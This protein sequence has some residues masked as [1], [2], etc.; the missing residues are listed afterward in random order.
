MSI[1]FREAPFKTSGGT[2]ARSLNAWFSDVINVAEFGSLHIDGSGFGTGTGDDAAC[3]Q[4][5]FDLAFGTV[6]APHGLTNKHLNRPVFIP[7]GR[8]QIET[9][10][11]LTQIVGGHISGAG[12]HA[13]LLEYSGSYPGG[14]V[15]LTPLLDINGATGLTVERMS[16]NMPGPGGTT[17]GTNSCAINLDWADDDT[18]SGSDGLHHNNFTDVIAGGGEW[19]VLI[20]KSGNEGHNNLFVNFTAATGQI[21]FEV[22]GPNAV[23]NTVLG[24]VGSCRVAYVRCPVGGGSIHVHGAGISGGEDHHTDADFVMESGKEMTLSGMRTE[25]HHCG[26][27]LEDGIVT[28]QGVA[29][30]DTSTVFARVNGGKLIMEGNVVGPL[31]E[32][33]GTGGEL[34]LSANWFGSPPNATPLSGYSGTVRWN[35]DLI[36]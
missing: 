19:A 34:Y 27:R 30:T 11:K 23:G 20:A 1:P 18:A 9:P 28:M 12:K 33:I 32:V 10:L 26:L 13:T 3:F 8:Y 2:T 6:A 4:A 36:A 21:G 22:K 17:L 29:V 24:G 16:L 14:F 7:A 5:A 25:A 35:P 15:T 31:A